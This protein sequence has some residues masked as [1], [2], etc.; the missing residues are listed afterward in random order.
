MTIISPLQ[1]DEAVWG[2]I[3]HPIT[4]PRDG[5]DLFDWMEPHDLTFLDT[6]DPHCIWTVV[7]TDDGYGMAIIPGRRRVNRRGYLV[8]Q[9]PW[10]DDLAELE[11][12]CDDPD[13]F[14]DE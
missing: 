5:C 1:I 7:D 13:D 9:V 3:F 12:I 10:T 11:V 4:N 8:T 2:E 14:D 6:V